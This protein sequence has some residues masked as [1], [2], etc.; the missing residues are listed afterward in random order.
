MSSSV[1]SRTMLH[2]VCLVKR[3]CSHSHHIFQCVF[4]ICYLVVVRLEQPIFS[5]FRTQS[6]HTGLLGFW[7]NRG[8]RISRCRLNL[9]ISGTNNSR[10]DPLDNSFGAQA[11]ILYAITIRLSVLSGFVVAVWLP[12]STMLI[13]RSY[14]YSC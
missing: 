3:H 9:G 14:R 1:C 13:S 6:Q 8:D 4:C 11:L 2:I 5:L 7:R 12:G 10:I